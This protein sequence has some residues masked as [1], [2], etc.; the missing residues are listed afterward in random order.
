MTHNSVFISKSLTI[1]GLM[2]GLTFTGSLHAA[3]RD[4]GGN[5]KIVNK[6]QAMV[7]EITTERDRLKTENEKT[8]AELE[9]L[10]SELEEKKSAAASAAAEKDQL[11]SE[12]SAQKSSADE[13][14]NRLD[15]TTAKLHEVIDKYNALN[16]A[17]NELGLE[18]SNL[19]NSQQQ[20]ASELKACESKNAKMYQATKEVINGYKSCQNRG[21]ID[22]FLESEPVLQI[23]TVE[24]ETLIQDFEDKLSKQQYHSQADLNKAAR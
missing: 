24:F 6:L 1:L 3:T 16:K 10:K 19:Q 13:T 2:I 12:L 18:H 17:K 5:A 8:V 9:K 11:S 22:T 20:T 15:N 21:V 7:K 14:R 4:A 23:N